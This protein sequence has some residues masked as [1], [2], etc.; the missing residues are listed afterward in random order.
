MTIFLIG[1]MG[2]GKSYWGKRWAARAGMS[3]SD[4][5]QLI[6]QRCGSSVAAIFEEKGEDY[7]R[8]LERQVLGELVME[9]NTI[10]ACGGGTPCYY[11]NMD[12]MNKRGITIYLK[13]TPALILERVKEETSSRPLLKQLNEAEILFFIEKKLKE[14]EPVYLQ[15]KICA[16]VDQL[17]DNFLQESVLPGIGN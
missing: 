9:K 12:R 15:A 8:Q 16:A 3:F 13:T 2:S 17:N 5:D 7:F 1:F 4:L 6:E 14:R 11:D 10:V